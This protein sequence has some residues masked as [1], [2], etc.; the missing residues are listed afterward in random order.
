MSTLCSQLSKLISV[1]ITSLAWDQSLSLFNRYVIRNVNVA[2]D[3]GVAP[4]WSWLSGRQ[5]LFLSF[6]KYPAQHNPAHLLSL[7]LSL[8]P[9][10]S[11]FLFSLS[12]FIIWFPL[13]IFLYIQTTPSLFFLCNFNITLIRFLKIFIFYHFFPFF[14]T[15]Q[16][17]IL[18]MLFFV[19][20]L[21][22]CFFSVIYIYIHTHTHTHIYIYIYRE[23]EREREIYIYIL[24]GNVCEA[25][26]HVFR[27]SQPKVFSIK[28]RVTNTPM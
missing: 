8:S 28:H 12:S 19:A 4:N 7:S 2:P 3:W 9:S 17:S 23:R 26:F 20:F 13:I 15:L 10:L 11:N 22:L 1:L 18:R 24:H 25:V 6:G 27:I 21:T 14:L 5:A 16:L